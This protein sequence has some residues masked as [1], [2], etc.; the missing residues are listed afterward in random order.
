MPLSTPLADIDLKSLK[1]FCTVVECGGFGGAQVLLNKSQPAISKHISHL[2]GRWGLRLCNRGRRG[3][4]VTDD[5]EAVYAAAKA[6][7]ASMDDFQTR[8]ASKTRELAGALRVGLIDNTVTNQGSKIATTIRQF[9][10]RSDKLGLDLEIASSSDLEAGVL[11]GS[12][13]VAIG[14]FH[15]Q[16][17]GLRYQPLF[18]ESHRLYCAAEHELASI[19]SED[20]LRARV[21][22]ARVVSVTLLTKAL[23]EEAQ[24]PARE[25]SATS[26]YLEAI[27][28]MLL[29]G[30]Y[31]GYLPTHYAQP[32]EEQGLLKPLLP[33]EAKLEATCMLITD[34][35]KQ[36]TNIAR[37]FIDDLLRN[38][39]D[40]LT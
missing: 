27:A 17:P 14:Y 31:I 33:D 23:A 1:V 36:P 8:V 9:L 39:D 28:Y 29:S 21:P 6:L 3:F 30:K 18:T 26:P 5:G 11:D 34:N 35:S 32:W 22:K 37:A 38:H 12:H 19:A 10:D 7:F 4:S 40:R 25:E 2:E 20:T 13:H 16:L 24:I 15:H